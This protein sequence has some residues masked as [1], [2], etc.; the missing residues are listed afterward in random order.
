MRTSFP[1]IVPNT[2]LLFINNSALQ[3]GGA[4]I[5]LKG[6]EGFRKCNRDL[7]T[8]GRTC[9]I[10]FGDTSADRHQLPFMRLPDDTFE[11]SMSRDECFGSIAFEDNYAQEGGNALYGG[12]LHNCI[13]ELPSHNPC[14]YS[15][16]YN[17]TCYIPGFQAIAALTHTSVEHLTR[18]SD[19]ITPDTYKVCVCDSYSTNC[20]QSFVNR[21]TFPGE[22]MMV[23]TAAVGEDNQTLPGMVAVHAE[24]SMPGEVWL[25]NELEETQATNTCTSLGYTLSS[26]SITSAILTLSTEGPCGSPG[27]PLYIFVKFRPCP[28][29]FALSKF[30]SCVCESRLQKY[31]NSC[32]INSR[33]FTRT[34]DF[35]VGF[36]S[37]HGLILHPHCPFD[38]CTLETVSFTF[39]TIDL[40]C[41][42][43]RS[44]TLC[45]G[46][47][48]GLSL[49]LGS[50]R[51][52]SCSNIFLLLF[53][54]FAIAGFILVI[55]L[56]IFKVTIADGTTNR[57]IFY[58]NVLA[59]NRSV[60]FPLHEA[61]ILTVFIAW[62]NLDLGIETCFI[63][64]IDEYTRTW[65][66][67]LFP[68]YIWLLVGLITLVSNH[69]ITIARII[70]PTNPI[71]VLAT[72]IL[73]SYTKLLR[74]II[75][76]FSFT[77]LEYPLD[78]RVAVWLY[79]GNIGYLEGKHIPLFLTGLLA[80]LFLFLP[81]TTFLLF[82]QCIV[83]GSNH[84]LL[85]WAN[86]PKVRS[87]LD[88]YHAPYKNRHRY[89][90]GLL[91][92]LRF[93]LLI[94]ATV[95]DVNSP[96]DPSVNLLVLGITCTGLMVLV[97]NTGDPYRKWYNSALESSFIL[98]LIILALASYQVKLEGGTQNLVG[99]TSTSIAFVTFQGIMAYHVV[100][101]VKETRIW[102]HSLGPK[103]QTLKGVLFRSHAQ[104]QNAI[105]MSVPPTAPPPQVTTTF[106]DLREPLLTLESQH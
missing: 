74:S 70:G 76:T 3:L 103:L 68:L 66:Q 33:S 80:L 39:D 15:E 72:L 4:I 82:G 9:F 23:S 27:I 65:L 13:V 91:L 46:C 12:A 89:W 96:R 21:T 34:G 100:K 6:S 105:E 36:D 24:I 11:S 49:N 92:L 32:D 5:L 60:F 42:H 102:R 51:C 45:G 94:I 55:F 29:G 57:L 69:S 2:S 85:S 28:F 43:G 64:G 59:V 1:C 54:T 53:L 67:F 83:S 75:A 86:N 14:R 88:A 7:D 71:A 50:S 84:K 17:Q 81:Y 38:Y 26:T 47:R 52:S 22:L 10:R 44:G 58:A 98:N 56:F 101:R 19:I 97:W 93:V 37:S 106:V 31:T 25:R 63:S 79:D 73:L 95:M 78:K 77:S 20:K 99:Y 30:G 41:D 8:P 18:D 62:L 87:F 35:W 61:N 16:C 48:S 90:T 40:Q 104:P